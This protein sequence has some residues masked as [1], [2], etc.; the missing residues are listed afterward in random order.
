MRGSC[1]CGTVEWE[2]DGD[3]S[4]KGMSHCHCTMCR[5]SHGTPFATFVGSDQSDF[6]FLHGAEAVRAYESS[7]GMVRNFCAHCGSPVSVEIG[8]RRAVPAGLFD[9]E[10]PRKPTMHIF[11]KDKARWFHIS[12]NLPQQDYYPAGVSRRVIDLPRVDQD[13]GAPSSDATASGSCNCGGV[14]FV[15]DGEFEAV[16]MCHCSRC[17]KAR[18]AAHCSNGFIPVDAIRFTSGEDLLETFALPQARSFAQAF[19]RVCGSAMPRLNHQRQVAVVPYGA[20]DT[21]PSRLPERHI[22]VS[23]KAVWYD[24][25]DGLP[26]FAEGSS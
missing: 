17:R 22:Y 6:K 15:V 9:D 24:I 12:D 11:T 3:F 25:E 8:P 26:Q 20:L 4:G 1:L 5:K 7:P 13:A 16:N 23:S 19:C 18:G 21:V 14:Q 2:F 10:P